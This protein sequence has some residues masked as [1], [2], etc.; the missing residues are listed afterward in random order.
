[1]KRRSYLV[2]RGAWLI[3]GVFLLITLKVKNPTHA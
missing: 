1:V 3:F 2:V